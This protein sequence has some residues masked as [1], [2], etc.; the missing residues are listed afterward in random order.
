MRSLRVFL[1]V[2]AAAAV[3][4]RLASATTP[5]PAI[6]VIMS[7]VMQEHQTSISGL[8]IRG[9]I[10]SPRLID[11]VSILPTIEWWRASNHVEPY[12]IETSRNDNTIGADARYDFLQMKTFVPYLGAGYSVHFL[13]SRV[14][15]PALGVND[16]SKSITKGGLD[17]LA[18]VSFPITTRVAN[19]IELKYHALSDY[20]QLKFNWGISVGLGH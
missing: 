1:V 12:G 16:A 10:H 20:Q 11:N 6:D 13:S 9:V 4:P 2:A 15:A 8:A 18:G 19:F 3:F 14:N 7:T 17:A 5:P